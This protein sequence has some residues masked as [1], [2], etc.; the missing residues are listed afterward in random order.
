M[1][2]LRWNGLFSFGSVGWLSLLLLC[3][4]LVQQGSGQ[5]VDP[6]RLLRELQELRQQ[7]EESEENRRRQM[8]RVIQ[9][10]SRDGQR[11]RELYEDAI[12]A[13]QFAGLTREGTQYRDWRSENAERLRS[14][15]F[16]T[17]L[18]LH[19]TYLA[20]TLEHAG[21]RPID[22][23]APQLFRF[24]EEIRGQDEMIREQRDLLRGSV[25]EG[26]F[27]RWLNLG[28]MLAEAEDW[29]MSPHNLNGMYQQTLLP[30]M[31][32]RGDQ[33][34][35]QYWD[36][37]IQQEAERAEEQGDF[38]WEQFETIRLPNLQWNRAEEYFHLGRPREGL[39]AKLRVIRANRDH[40]NF[41]RWYEDLESLLTGG[42][43]E[44]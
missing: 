8:L 4:P 41:D 44:S 6:E 19:L 16:Q 25:A 13:T 30:W 12:R 26:V 36:A 11:A 31:R 33:R 32:E 14:R 42:E 43:E 34:V 29:E 38:D 9:D 24:T 27:A 2:D 21:G 23:I 40:P 1:R 18:Q 15:N 10:A 5:T 28:P 39:E 35:F 3:G 7:R 20:L 17:A 37:R 22:D